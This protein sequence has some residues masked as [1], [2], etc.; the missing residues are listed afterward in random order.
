[1][2][3]MFVWLTVFASG[4]FLM[5][6]CF[7]CH[8]SLLENFVDRCIVLAKYSY[9]VYYKMFLLP[10]LLAFFFLVLKEEMWMGVVWK[11]R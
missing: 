5:M 3:C 9:N 6:C 2:A 4:L 11:L 7:H 10:S 1:M 8:D